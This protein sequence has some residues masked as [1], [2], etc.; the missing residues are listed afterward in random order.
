M[1]VLSVY[2]PIYGVEIIAKFRWKSVFLKGFHGI[3]LCTN[4]SAGYHAV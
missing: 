1:V 2:R 3:P 4:E